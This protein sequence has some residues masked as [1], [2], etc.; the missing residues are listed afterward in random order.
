MY[1]FSFL[2]KLSIFQYLLNY[3]DFQKNTFWGPGGFG[4]F[5]GLFSFAIGIAMMV[6]SVYI[7]R[8]YRQEKLAVMYGIGDD[9]YTI[10]PN[11]KTTA[12]SNYSSIKNP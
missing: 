3:I 11:N 7:F 2:K 9:G 10:M 4:F 8:R 5:L 12:A 1:P 6:A